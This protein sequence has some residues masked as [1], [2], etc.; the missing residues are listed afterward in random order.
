MAQ[1]TFEIDKKS[2][3]DISNGLERL[4]PKT[5]TQNRKIQSAMRKA[6]IPLKQALKDEIKGAIKNKK[7]STRKLQKSIRVF[8]SARNTVYGRPSVY[9]GPLVKVPKNIKKQ[10]GRTEE[11]IAEDAAAYI[12]KKSGF[13]FYFL[14]YGF[15]PRGSK[16]KVPGL[17]LLPKAAKT[18]GKLALDR[19]ERD[20]VDMLN[21][22]AM[23]QLGTKII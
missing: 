15:G 1:A 6:A 8:D 4:F 13:Y 14:E 22:N 7:R 17:G 23:K 9:V 10:D 3:I 2:L 19:M 5:K 16:K 18:G 21:K 12:K 11:Q 20:I